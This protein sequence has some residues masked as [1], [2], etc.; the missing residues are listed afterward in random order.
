MVQTILCATTG[1]IFTAIGICAVGMGRERNRHGTWFPI[2]VASLLLALRA[3]VA[4]AS[5]DQSVAQPFV[6]GDGFT[7]AVAG[8]MALGIFRGM[9]S[10]SGQGNIAPGLGRNDSL[11]SDLLAELEVLYDVAPV[12]LCLIDAEY[13]FVRVSKKLADNNG[14][15]VDEY[16]G[17]HFQD[18]IPQIFDR[19]EPIFRQVFETGQPVVDVEVHCTSSGTPHDVRS[20]IAGFHPVRRENGETLGINIVVEDVTE[21]V[22]TVR[23]LESSEARL[24]KIVDQVPAMIFGKDVHGRFTL[25][26][27]ATAATYGLTVEGIIGRHHADLHPV[28]EQVEEFLENDREIIAG[29]EPRTFV[30]QTFTDGAGRLHC[31]HT[32]KIPFEFGD[33]EVPGVLG[34]AVDV[35]DWKF[36][37]EALSRAHAEL[38]RRV[39]ERTAE[40][41]T[42][43]KRLEKVIADHERAAAALAASEQR[44][45]GILDNTPAYV[46][47]KDRDG[48]YLIANRRVAELFKRSPEEIY[49]K[50]DFDILPDEVA[51][52]LSHNDR[53]VI[54]KRAA[55]EFDETLMAEDGPH[56]YLSM[57]FPLFDADGVPYA[58]GGISTDITERKRVLAE[59][60]SKQRVLEQLLET[61][62]RDRQLTA[63]EIHD[64]FVQE[65]TAAL[66]FLE[67]ARATRHDLSDDMK[68]VC[69][70][71][72]ELLRSAIAEAR[73]LI[74]CLRPPILDERGIVAAIEY[75]VA[76]HVEAGGPPVEF[77]HDNNLARLSPLLQSTVFR[78]VQE[79]LTNVRRHSKSPRARLDLSQS[80]D[81][82]H[83]DIQDFG[84]GFDPKQT[85]E[86]RFGLAGIRQRAKAVNGWAKIES[87]PGAGTTVEIDL[88]R[89]DALEREALERDRAEE[90]LRLSEERFRS[91]VDTA[92][93]LIYLLGVDGTIEYLNRT[94]PGFQL[95]HVL[96]TSAYDY[97]SNR[98]QE[99][100]RSNIERV[101]ISGE[102][103]A[104]ELQSVGEFN[105]PAWYAIRLGPRWRDGNIVGVT[106]IATDITQRKQAEE[107]HRAA[108]SRLETML[109]SGPAVHYARTPGPDFATIYVSENVRDLLG[110]EAAE[111]LATPRFWLDHI[112]NADRESV[113][114]ALDNGCEGE[115]CTLT[116]RMRH[117]DGSYVELRDEWRPLSEPDA[118]TREFI[119]RWSATPEA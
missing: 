72:F 45:Q 52:Q 102:Y 105:A 92:P 107:R 89:L 91:L 24:R 85:V 56:T 118:Q 103:T 50:T 93:D 7:L 90:T 61:H 106:S 54:T 78:I 41:S 49:G 17:A 109:S 47:L 116:Y 68:Q 31:L 110:H 86:G 58:V 4:L 6:G 57:K 3:A 59:L 94:A 87:I 80:D 73:R 74:S 38:E 22:R 28:P 23:A 11:A 34:I 10:A 67:T 111:I 18:M 113:V 14:R 104:F 99:V 26:N 21:H 2:A 69:Q 32:T 30:E 43:N 25:A 8:L 33:D 12:G 36:A 5:Q 88:P 13:R 48:R 42:A 60:R 9:A 40:L 64:G 83:L 19:L 75:L 29:G 16:Y 95:E 101:L 51:R 62:E 63:Y 55:T 112:H 97:M 82:I 65:V 108:Q 84:V 76:E 96:G 70:R 27:R 119:G 39:A 77:V 114:A 115:G 35:T 100:L 53:T 37:T 20:W 1:L 15:T 79:A 81:R 66:M 117:Q 98:D 71:G 44:L 46:Y